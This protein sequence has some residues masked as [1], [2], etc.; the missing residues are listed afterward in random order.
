MPLVIDHSREIAAPAPVVWQVLTD[1][2][3]YQQWNPFAVAA[4]CD[5]R[6]G[7]RFTMQVALVGSKPM[8]QTEFVVSV[9]EG[10]GF[11]YAM[12]PA[13]AGLLRSIREQ[14]IVDLGAGR[15]RYTSHFQLDGPMAP[16][17]DLVLGRALRRGFGGNVDALARRAEQ[18]AR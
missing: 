18:L 1:F 2:G 3:A 5:L 10:E 13:P 15:S 12:R 4:Q 6:P 9:D 8:T 11:A 14:R 17:V 16:V 7:G